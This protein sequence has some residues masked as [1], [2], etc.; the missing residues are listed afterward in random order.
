MANPENT[1]SEAKVPDGREIMRKL[2][3]VVAA[4]ARLVE[5]QH[6]T[7]AGHLQAPAKAFMD[8]AREFAALVDAAMP[9]EEK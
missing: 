6:R 1:A 3:R 5:L 7:W 2:S 4:Q 8:E 9:Q